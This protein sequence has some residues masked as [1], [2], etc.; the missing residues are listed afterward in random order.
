MLGSKSWARRVPS[1]SGPLVAPRVL[2]L[3]EHRVGSG[4]TAQHGPQ[5]RQRKALRNLGQLGQM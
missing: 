1:V 3:C 5:Y 4:V 2:R